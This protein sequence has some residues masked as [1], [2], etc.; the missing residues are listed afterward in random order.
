MKIYK[1]KTSPVL[2]GSKIETRY[3]FNTFLVL[4]VIITALICG[5]FVVQVYKYN[6][7]Y[8]I[9]KIASEF[10]RFLNLYEHPSDKILLNTVGSTLKT[11]K[12]I[13]A[14]FDKEINTQTL[15][16]TLY[17]DRKNIPISLINKK[18]TSYANFNIYINEK[19]KSLSTGTY[20][21]EKADQMYLDPNYWFAIQLFKKEGIIVRIQYPFEF[22]VN[23]KN[24]GTTVIKKKLKGDLIYNLGKERG[25]VF[26]LN[27]NSVHL[28]PFRLKNNI[29]ENI[30]KV[31][32]EIHLPEKIVESVK[33][34]QNGGL[35]PWNMLNIE[36]YALFFAIADMSK[37]IS[38]DWRD[39]PILYNTK[40]KLFEPIALGFFDETKE[41]SLRDKKN[42]LTLRDL[43][44]YVNLGP[45]VELFKNDKFVKKYLTTLNRISDKNYTNKFLKN[46]T[47]LFYSFYNSIRSLNLQ[48]D[49]P[50]KKYLHNFSNSS[51]NIQLAFFNPALGTNAF[52]HEQK[53][54]G[55]ISINITA[56]KVIPIELV[57]LEVGNF[58]TLKVD[59]NS[60]N[61]EGRRMLDTPN[62][63]LVDFHMPS[64]ENIPDLSSAEI[65]ITYYL[66]GSN[67]LRREKVEKLKM[68]SLTN[69]LKNDIFRTKKNYESYLNIFSL[70]KQKTVLNLK[71]K[72]LTLRENMVIPR[73][74]TLNISSGTAIT[75]INNSSLISFS[76][77]EFNGT[78]EEP[79]TVQ[80]S[81]NSRGGFAVINAGKSSLVNFTSFRGL[82]APKNGRWELTG[83][84]TFYSSP[85][86]ITNSSFIN[87]KSEDGLNIIRSKFTIRSS[88]F[89]NTQSDALDVDFSVGEITNSKF[90]NSGNDAMDFSGSNIEL[91]SIEI[92]G[93]QDKGISSGE[94]S[95][96]KAR[97]ITIRNT[98]FGFVSKDLSTLIVKD[99]RL[100]KNK[101]GF[102]GYIKKNEYGPAR[103]E[104]YDIIFKEVDKIHWIEDKSYFILN[105]EKIDGEEVGLSNKIYKK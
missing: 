79:I 76:A 38:W 27:K 47:H 73:G 62:Y 40:T 52:L 104:A 82:S 6:N 3:I 77:V 32:T 97:N 24:R 33:A 56:R 13:R 83:A 16:G 100:E 28:K 68:E 58:L 95:Y 29:M 17:L 59:K 9:K 51:A 54:N 88:N 44:Q 71:V 105:G 23:Q 102:S 57:E 1:S 55:D 94:E 90:V 7:H 72:N 103:I 78:K 11:V 4:L 70:N 89:N 96:V 66:Q 101:I 80:S 69:F 74:Y 75:L 19:N 86:D 49:I 18:T 98:M 21:L 34:Y 30:G 61:I 42:I 37:Y 46:N 8:I 85:V 41:R 5:A 10:D 64:G 26:L 20:I 81:P 48:N 53:N 63:K 67:T 2:S 36:K 60:K 87:N 43:E 12:A 45:Y 39:I 22:I 50:A 84:V 25:L 93:V 92:D 14:G 15:D 65:F 99:S 35:P 31:K 91:R